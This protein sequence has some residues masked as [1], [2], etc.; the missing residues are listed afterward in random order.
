MAA[1]GAGKRVQV[2]LS[3]S[4]VRR[5]GPINVA[6]R[7]PRATHLWLSITAEPGGTPVFRPLRITSTPVRRR[8]LTLGTRYMPGGRSY[9]VRASPSRT[10]R[11][12]GLARLAVVPRS[13]VPLAALLPMLLRGPVR[14][15]GVPGALDE[16][17]PLQPG[18]RPPLP[19]TEAEPGPDRSRP[20]S[21]EPRVRDR[22]LSWPTD[23]PWP[24]AAP[25]RVRDPWATGTYYT[26]AQVERVLE[27]E[28][29]KRRKRPWLKPLPEG[30]VE[31]VMLQLAKDKAAVDRVA[32]NYDLTRPVAK[33]QF[34]TE[35]DDRVCVRCRSLDR[36]SWVPWAWRP[37]IPVH[38]NCRCHYSRLFP[39]STGRAPF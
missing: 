14:R 5:G 33:Y 11:W 10:M 12:A 19:R 3:P 29:E 17:R 24:G 27:R 8:D 16:G 30:S 31:D 15:R 23:E 1:R 4:E 38:P 9:V 18:P 39:P 32:R 7:A 34:H 13:V 6:I 25:P 28:R 21:W 20:D 2:R 35:R 37:A 26:R 22:P 36:R